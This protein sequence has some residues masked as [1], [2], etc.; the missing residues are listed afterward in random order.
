MTTVARPWPESAGLTLADRDQV[1][2]PF[3]GAEASA[4]P[5]TW[6]Q[7][8]ILQDMRDNASQFNMSGMTNLPPGAG[9]DYAVDRLGAL[10]VRHAALRMRLDADGG[11]QE[12][13]G[14]GRLGLDVW[15][16]PDEVDR[17]GVARYVD[18]LLATW[19]LQP[20]DFQRDWPL[21]MAVLRHRGTWLHLVWELSHLAAD[22]AAHLL[23]LSDL[24]P[25]GLERRAS[26]RTPVPQITDVA[27]GEQ[28]AQARQLSVRAMRYWEAQLRQLQALTFGA[29]ARP[30]GRDGQRFWKVRFSSPAAHLAALAIARR[31]GTDASRVTLALVATAI[32]RAAG[33]GQLT[34]NF[35]INNRF[36]PGL[37]EVIAPIAQNSAITI[38][39]ADASIDEVVRR[40]RGACTSAGMRAYY[41]PADLA[42]V[43]AR[44]E[45]ERGH[46]A[47]VSCRVNDQRAMV[48]RSGEDTGQAQVSLDQLRQRRAESE[49]TWLGPLDQLHDQAVLLVENRPGVLSLYLMCDLWSLSEGQV[50]QLLRGV[51]DAAIEA[52]SDPAAPTRVG[53]GR[54]GRS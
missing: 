46:P 31:T 23:L 35:M 44:L 33:L 49:L 51:E 10:M 7:K 40:T 24:M 37:A 14:S 2:V 54:P 48:R 27:R 5:L 39:V 43:T 29:P 16:I 36:R 32:G 15:T 19:P 34:V 12:I 38:E 18:Q 28:S 3:T 21:R 25:G 11:G 42:M 8:S 30:A 20:F 41:D 22:G 6:G 4:E 9:L 17:A 1:I 53:G 13:A 45:A 50:E 47:R 52:A 26:A